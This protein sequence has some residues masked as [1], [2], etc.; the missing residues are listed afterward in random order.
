MSNSFLT[1]LVD[2]RSSKMSIIDA[3]LAVASDEERD[4]SDVELANIK[5]L[6]SEVE[7]LDERI[8]QISDLE[9]R[10]V[11]A[12]AV[13]A[14]VEP[15]ETRTAP[16]RVIDEPSVYSPVSE[17]RFLEDAL[18]VE[19]GTSSDASE[20][21]T[22]HMNEMKYQYRAAS[23]S[24]NFA[25]LVV[26][27]YLVDL[28]APLRRAGTATYDISRKHPLPA[29][30]MSLNIARM[31][32]GTTTY[33]QSSE[34]T[35]PTF[36]NPD[37]T[38]LTVA[39]NTLTSAVDL[40]KQAI[41]RGTNVEDMVI[42]DMISSAKNK[43]DA[44]ILNG[45]DGTAGEPEG[46]LNQANVNSRTYTD[47]S[48]TWA[49]FFPVLANAVADIPANYFGSPTHIVIHPS[50]WG[51]WSRVLDGSN[52][53][54]FTPT[55]GNPFNSPG[56]YNAPGYNTG[57]YQLLGLP[58]VVDA[59]MPTNLGAGTN[60]TAVVIG[61]FEES[62]VWEENAGTPYY[63][64]FEQP[65]GQV[66]IRVVLYSFYAYTAGRYATAFSKITG[67]GLVTANWA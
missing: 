30:G 32:T 31:T 37:D 34:G 16:A 50:L 15:T 42:T 62:H 17:A 23:T 33:A 7:K 59:N 67:T 38:L 46:I 64:K 66:A 29:A 18:A 58:V 51:V 47:G 13:I 55:A 10:R 53:P 22:R 24:S 36:S 4:L 35:A 11:K 27:Q 45:N 2:Q 1:K 48:P 41:L 57:G 43:L 28:A 12:E 20:R 26:P 19:M 52:R 21:M 9:D 5:A 39:V 40:S 8:V 65:D 54:L 6:S 44:L 56:T 25:G 63:V 3:T 60:E 61:N 49:E 14:K